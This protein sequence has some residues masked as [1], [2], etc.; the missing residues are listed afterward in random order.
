MRVCS[1]AAEG[2][3]L[4]ISEGGGGR[5]RQK[6]EEGKECCGA[7]VE[8]EQPRLWGLGQ[9]PSKHRILLFYLLPSLRLF[10]MCILITPSSMPP[11]AD[12]TFTEISW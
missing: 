4:F 10:L 3:N 1:S 6:E 9:W 2:E 8:G 5:E 11:G 7:A 12:L